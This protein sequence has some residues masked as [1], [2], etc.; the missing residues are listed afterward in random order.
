MLVTAVLIGAGNRGAHAYGS[1]ALKHKDEL[2]FVAVAEPDNERRRDF[3]AAHGIPPERCFHSWEQA[4]AAGKLADVLFNCTQ[5]DM[6]LE[7][8]LPFI[9]LGYAI[10]LEKPMSN[11]LNKV[12][13]LVRYARQ[14]KVLLATCHVMR[15]TRFYKTIKQ[16][17]SSGE[18]GNVYSM[19]HR[20]NVTWWHMA[21]SF[22]R[23]HWGNSETTSPMILA[24][25]CHD[26]DIIYW[27]MGQVSTL[28]S[29]GSLQYY[30]RENAPAGAALRCV[31]CVHNTT[32]QFS[33]TRFYLKEAPVGWPM[34]TISE[35]DSLEARREA[36]ENGPYGR[37]VFQCDNNV[38]DNQVVGLSFANGASG[39]FTMMGHSAA[40]G[41]TMRYDGT[42]GTLRAKSIYRVLGNEEDAGSEIALY[43]HASG[44]V[45]HFRYDIEIDNT[46]DVAAA[47]HQEGNEGIMASFL[48][49]FRGEP[50][51]LTDA[52]DSAEGHILAFA[53]EDSRL[54][55]GASIEIGQFKK[56]MNCLL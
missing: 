15:Y 5:D 37:C 48:Q 2:K 49:A 25:S 6:H 30:R 22:V 1:Y 17:I 38:V 24:K 12:I 45:K 18:L 54:R 36:I 42:K 23:G 3:A 9:D 33:A 39:T 52:V 40:E 20:E 55:G 32:C 28:S 19:E 41:R 35:E 11:R 44:K 4:A 51:T 26:L 31:D 47:G 27:N 7:S 21:H 56:E 34:R 10:L 29:F 16:I 46:R 13:D 8:T 43:D 50:S 14:K 53:C